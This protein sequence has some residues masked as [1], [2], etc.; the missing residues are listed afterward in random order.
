MQFRKALKLAGEFRHVLIPYYQLNAE[1]ESGRADEII[2]TVQVAEKRALGS[3]SPIKQAS[4][5]FDRERLK[6]SA[7]GFY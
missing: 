5:K 1:M 7:A 2:L 3:G 6:M 4:G